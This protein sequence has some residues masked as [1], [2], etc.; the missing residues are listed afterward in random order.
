MVGDETR[1]QHCITLRDYVRLDISE[2]PSKHLEQFLDLCD[3]YK[4]ND[5]SDETIKLSLFLFTLKDKAKKNMVDNVAGGSFMRKEILE[6]FAPLDELAT[7]N[8]EFSID[9]IPPRR[10]T[11]MHEIDIVSTVEAHIEILIKRLDKFTN[12]SVNFVVQVCENCTSNHD[13]NV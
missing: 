13:S 9:R 12:D 1:P 11:R 2:D 10:P 6:S 3:N 8:F 5:V 4:Q 7:T